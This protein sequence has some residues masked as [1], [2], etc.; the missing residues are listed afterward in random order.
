MS[1][2]Q[3]SD[4]AVT[5][6]NE[7]FIDLVQVRSAGSFGTGLLV[8]RGLVLTAL[9]CARDPKNSWRIFD[10]LGVCLL[11]E[12]QRGV[13]YSYSA[14]I[15]WPSTDTF[16]EDPPDVAVLQIDVPNPPEAL[17]R[18]RFGELP[19][20]PT[21]GTARGFPKATSGSQLLGGRIEHNQPG[22]VT[23][24]SHTRRALTI[25][26]T[27]R[28][29]LES[30]E[31]WAGLSGGPLLIDEL[32]VG[33]MRNVP[34][35]WKGEAVEAEPLA[36]LLRNAT[37]ASLRSLLGVDLPLTA[38]TGNRQ[39]AEQWGVN[40]PPPRPRP[41]TAPELSSRFV[42]RPTELAKLVGHILDSDRGSPIAGTTAVHGGGGFG[43]TTLATALCHDP[44]VRAAFDGGILWVQ[45][46][47]TTSQIDVLARLN[48]QIRLLDPN[49]PTFSEVKFASA[50]FRELLRGRNFLVVLD[51]LWSESLLPFFRHEGPTVVTTRLRRIVLEAGA[52]VV[53]DRLTSEEAVDLLSRWL[54]EVPDADQ[55]LA[56]RDLSA[57]LGEWALL[58]QLVGAELGLQTVGGR[59][60]LEAIHHVNDGFDRRGFTYL[61]QDSEFSRN[62]AI[63]ASLDAS[64]TM[65]TP[66]H[67]ERFHELGIL[68]GDEDLSFQTIR[69][70]W[71]ATAGYDEFATKKALEAMQRLALFTRY[72]AG[73]EILR[74]HEVIGRVLADRLTDP[75]GLNAK[76]VSHWGDAKRLPDKYA[77]R[78]L[79]F[80][81]RAADRHSEARRLLFDFDWIHAKLRA[82]G[83]VAVLADYQREPADDSDRRLVAS[84]LTIA[85]ASLMDPDQLPAQLVGR[86]ERLSG[87]SATLRNL[88]EKARAHVSTR[89]LLPKRVFLTSM[90]QDVHRTIQ[91]GAPV[92]SGTLSRDK[93]HLVIGLR[94]GTVQIWDWRRQ[95]RV[96]TLE[97]GVG[98]IFQLDMI[99]ERLA[100][101]GYYDRYLGPHYPRPTT[102]VEVWN[103]TSRERLYSIAEDAS[104]VEKGFA[105][106]L[107]GGLAALTTGETN[108]LIRLY[109][110]T[111]NALP[112]VIDRELGTGKIGEGGRPGRVS[113]VSDYLLYQGHISD[114]I[115]VWMTGERRYRGH[116]AGAISHQQYW[117]AAPF[118]V[119]GTL[120]VRDPV[121]YQEELMMRPYTSRPSRRSLPSSV[122]TFS[123]PVDEKDGSG[124]CVRHY[125]ER[126]SVAIGSGERIFVCSDV[127]KIRNS[128]SEA[129]VGLLEGHSNTIR[130]VDLLEDTIITASEDG[131][132]RIWD[133]P[134]AIATPPAIERDA[135][136]GERIKRFYQ[137]SITR[138]AVQ[139]SSAFVGTH[140]SL[141]EWNWNKA[142]MVNAVSLEEPI[143]ALAVDDKWLVF[144]SFWRRRGA[145]LTARLR[146]EWA[147]ERPRGE[148]RQMQEFDVSN[149]TFDFVEQGAE[150]ATLLGDTCAVVV[151][152]Y[153]SS[154][155]DRIYVMD[156][157][158]EECELILGEQ[159]SAVALSPHMVV[160]GTVDGHIDIWDRATGTP[161]PRLSNHSGPIAALQIEGDR[162]LSCSSDR[163]A[164]VWDLTT[165]KSI[166]TLPHDAAVN[167]LHARGGLLVTASE[168]HILRVFDL[169]GGTE[170]AR[171]TDDAPLVAC[172][173]ATEPTTIIC[174][175]KSGQLHILG[176]NA[177]LSAA[178]SNPK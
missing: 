55:K 41:Y 10:D 80:H 101:G 108:N 16:G 164:Q 21:D 3:P 176:V 163:T 152:S 24:T 76:L 82:V 109:D 77:W 128:T 89:A 64:L 173:I 116:I 20:T 115:D 178:I 37:D 71:T 171:F 85:G 143:H 172:E 72:H 138:I 130:S 17:V 87:S 19:Q 29:Q 135:E 161:K 95:D 70:L 94:N 144:S 165:F 162:L 27:G 7:P 140:S 75:T 59:P 12:L 42:Q 120:Y 157:R 151:K 45:F 74:L 65:L 15:V 146:A 106:C 6:D 122:Q 54:Q 50:G 36:P 129:V 132:A 133:W 112:Q 114:R 73:S 110:W 83:P 43:K 4:M 100:V 121:S 53:I 44:R 39:S 25:D 32:I 154:G 111:T 149:G 170:L 28:H 57:R 99:G 131:T 153:W 125:K 86:L 13:E 78:N 134:P 123:C 167:A 127:V 31:R 150:A 52:A 38:S 58:L 92:L 63:G 35:G 91:V 11:R 61:D 48:D 40:P 60:L 97:C 169:Q 47:E 81:L 166:L 9:H 26:A 160:G 49:S 118:V 103:W 18:H 68:R 104:G 84:A 51:D 139:G 126:V 88:L 34:E 46:T 141:E 117:G 124:L 96:A 148:H 119:D 33:V 66:D 107:N 142:E 174:G 158:R 155:S 168:D 159:I 8:G 102:P 22:R 2:L 145:K 156:L 62:S 1:A 14:H 56:L 67:R 175:G 90:A 23:Y 147:R 93:V 30:R 69:Q 113:I 137:P 79:L 136:A 177:P 98:P 5:P 105:I